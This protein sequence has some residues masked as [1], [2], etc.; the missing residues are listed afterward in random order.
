MPATRTCGTTSPS[1][2]YLTY[3]VVPITVAAVLWHRAP[4]L[5]HRYVSLWIGLSFAALVTYAAL[6]GVAAVA[7][8]P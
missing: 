4:H 1:L 2:V 7:R 6:P 5:F 8:E 3:F